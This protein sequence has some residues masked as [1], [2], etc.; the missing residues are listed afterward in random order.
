MTLQKELPKQK[1]SAFDAIQ[2]TSYLMF[3]LNL[4]EC[5]AKVHYFVSQNQNKSMICTIGVIN[6]TEAQR[7]ECDDMGLYTFLET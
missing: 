5:L 1:F 2:T 4:R 7:W 6:L 3:S